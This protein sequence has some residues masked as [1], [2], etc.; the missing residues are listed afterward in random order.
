MKIFW[1]NTHPLSLIRIYSQCSR[2]NQQTCSEVAS[3]YKKQISKMLLFL[4][5]AF[6]PFWLASCF[7][8]TTPPA[9]SIS[10]LAI[11]HQAPSASVLC[12]PFHCDCDSRHQQS[13]PLAQ[14]LLKSHLSRPDFL[15]D[16]TSSSIIHNSLSFP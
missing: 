2:T 6:L 13:S 10:F 7:L 15:R 9:W 11:K 8:V 12:T 5:L 16:S 3:K 1:T 4:V 14:N